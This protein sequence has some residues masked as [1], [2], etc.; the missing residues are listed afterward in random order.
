MANVDLI[1]FYV[2]A[3]FAAVLFGFTLYKIYQSRNTANWLC[4]LAAASI[5][6]KAGSQLAYLYILWSSCVPRYFLIYFF[7]NLA[8]IVLYVL[9]ELRLAVFFASRLD[10]H[11]AVG[12]GFRVAA[13]VLL[14]AYTANGIA[15]IA[16][17][18]SACYINDAGGASVVGSMPTNVKYTGY[19]IEIALGLVLLTGNF[20]A[21][22]G[23]IRTSRS[24]GSGNG[25][26]SLYTIVL[27]S[28]ALR[29]LAVVPVEVY[30]IAV[31][32]D[33]GF[34]SGVFPYGAGN[35]NYGFQQVLDVYK[36]AIL[37][38]LLHLPSAYA[39]VASKARS[40]GKLSHSTS[41]RSRKSN[42]SANSVGVGGLSSPNVLVKDDHANP[43]LTA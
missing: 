42:L 12:L 37:L 1:L 40:S 35:G 8:K 7:L 16:I 6:I 17:Y 14:T 41:Q 19:S 10:S 18:C 3:A 21:L 30:K 9:H 11:R 38:V 2:A 20:V 24:L 5:C 31:S 36:V 22:L 28:D 26:S 4:L 43:G 34:N 39:R 23:I 29:F 15:Q 25:S 32:Y 33:P 13:Y 27:G